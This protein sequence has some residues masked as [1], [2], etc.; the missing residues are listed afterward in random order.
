MCC[1][2][3]HQIK[4]TKTRKKKTQFLEKNQW[5]CDDGRR[6]DQF[7]IFLC[8]TWLNNTLYKFV[9]FK[10]T[11]PLT[12]FYQRAPE[13]CLYHPLLSHDQLQTRL[14]YHLRG[15]VYTPLQSR[16][17]NF[18]NFLRNAINWPVK[19]LRCQNTTHIFNYT[20][21]SKSADC[22]DSFKIILIWSKMLLL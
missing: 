21:T 17:C 6:S 2:T 16:V 19:V 9:C 12:R 10:H 20:S 13:A 7:K 5:Q 1:V 14:P 8:Y 18:K 11:K 3:I 15:A 22:G 4:I